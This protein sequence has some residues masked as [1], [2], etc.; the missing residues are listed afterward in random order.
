MKIITI[1]LFA[2][3]ACAAVSAQARNPSSPSKP[4]Q[5]KSA[6]DIDE[7]TK[8]LEKE[9]RNLVLVDVSQRPDLARKYQISV[10]PT[11]VAVTS[12]GLVTARLA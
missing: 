10:V 5:I 3:A 9:G 7:V 12:E 4:F 1:F 2:L 11:A 8:E 6:K